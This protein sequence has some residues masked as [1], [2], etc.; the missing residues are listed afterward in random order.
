M[1]EN[2]YPLL[3]WGFGETL[4]R[5]ECCMDLSAG[6]IKQSLLDYQ[7][8]IG[9]Y[10]EKDTEDKVHFIITQMKDQVSVSIID[11][12]LI[13]GRCFNNSDGFMSFTFGE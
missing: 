9:M 11:N 4:D 10:I 6:T 13:Y 12:D 7:M 5:I 1:I 3:A 2:D 8:W